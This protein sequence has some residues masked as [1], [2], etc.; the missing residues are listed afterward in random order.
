MAEVNAGKE[1]QADLRE[2][3]NEKN[4]KLAKLAKLAK[5]KTAELLKPLI[6]ELHDYFVDLINK[7]TTPITV[8]EVDIATLPPPLN[9]R[10]G[11]WTELCAAFTKADGSQTLAIRSRN[12]IEDGD[13]GGNPRPYKVLVLTV[14]PN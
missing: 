9:Q 11:L 1:K 13:N 12:E 7:Q 6:G 2:V 14:N 3:V 5:E 8:L 10:F 4:N